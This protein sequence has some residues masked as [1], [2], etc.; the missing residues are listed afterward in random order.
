VIFMNAAVGRV[1]V[2]RRLGG[3]GIELV[4]PRPAPGRNS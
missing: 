3:E 1:Q 2:M 4:D